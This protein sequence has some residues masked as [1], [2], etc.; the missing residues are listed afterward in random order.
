MLIFKYILFVL[1]AVF[2]LGCEKRQETG[3][4]IRS[5]EDLSHAR[6]ASV[7]STLGEDY[8]EKHFPNSGAWYYDDMP[9]AV[10]ALK[11]GRVDA[12]VTV[13]PNALCVLNNNPGLALMPKALA[14]RGLSLVVAKGNVALRDSINRVIRE[15]KADGT[16]DE[17]AGHWINTGDISQVR[18]DTDNVQSDKVLRIGLSATY[19]P[20][21]FINAEGEIA[22]YEADMA[23]CVAG[24]LGMRIEL[25][26]IKFSGMISA[27][28]AGTVDAI[29]SMQSSADKSGLCAE[30]SEPY[31]EGDLVVIIRDP[32]ATQI[33]H[34]EEDWWSEQKSVV[35]SNL[36]EE[37]RYLLIMD[38]LKT[39]IL[40]TLFAAVLGTLLGFMACFVRI[41][42]NDFVH[43]AAEVYVAVLQ[44]IPDVV[45]LMLCFYVIFVPMHLNAITVSIIAF[46]FKFSSVVAELLGTAIKG[47]GNGQM[48]AGLALGFS[49]S[50]VYRYIIIPQAARSAL[51]SYLASFSEL[52]KATAI[53]GII[54][55]TDLATAADI[56]RSRTFDAFF[57]LVVVSIIY[58]ILGWVITFV[59]NR[60]ILHIDSK[61]RK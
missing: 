35:Y 22:G 57:P 54:A 28:Q 23:R 59:F 51:P 26:S 46:A 16:L 43:K 4:E 49:R 36:V 50:E 30:F 24:R 14:H 55:V 61:R 33:V 58:F 2:C 3:M 18:I 48:E 17:F 6:M 38:G 40:I 20:F 15:M 52:F 37:R 7:I 60:F 12:V 9:G 11:T 45:W 31:Y 1:T 34:G 8:L 13:Y 53:V 5:V 25:R 44:G 39:T 42:E 47:I 32:N 27:L 29:A 21:A 19:P 56:I 41:S 10:E